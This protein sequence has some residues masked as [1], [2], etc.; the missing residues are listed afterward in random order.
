MKKSLIYLCLFFVSFHA[1]SQEL[2]C[3][4]KIIPP[5][6]M[7]SGPEVFQTMERAIEEFLNGRKWSNSLYNSNY[8]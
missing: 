6:V 2:N 4:V 5:R 7:I 1:F 8:D 3:D